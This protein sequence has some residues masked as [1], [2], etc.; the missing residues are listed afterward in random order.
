MFICSQAFCG[1]V[2]LSPEQAGRVGLKVWKNEC[3]GTVEGLVSWND[4]E[5]FAS[6]GI[7][8]FIWYPEGMRGPFEE[9]FPR[10]VA[11][12]VSSGMELPQVLKEHKHC[13]WRDRT[14]FQKASS[15][16][17]MWQLRSFLKETFPLQTTFLISRMEAALPKMQEGLGDGEC[18]RLVSRFRGLAATAHGAYAMIDYV[19]FKG[20]GVSEKERYGGEG[21][22]LKQVLLGMQE[23][24]F[25][26]DQCLAFSESAKR[27]LTRRVKNSPPERKESRWL[28][29]WLNR[30]DTYRD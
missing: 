22:G 25:H 8:H 21:W 20:E 17:Q 24:I 18:G 6:L 16:V 2:F 1:A 4:G 26:K 11:L 9:S 15:S 29:G 14:T 30:C 3:G 19:N 10:L 5:D 7:G 12:A 23:E 13:P 28:Q 27:V